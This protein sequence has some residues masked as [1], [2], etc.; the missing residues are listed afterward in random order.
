MVDLDNK[1]FANIYSKILYRFRNSIAHAE[2]KIEENEIKFCNTDNS[3]IVFK[4]R[5]ERKRVEK[6]MEDLLEEVGWRVIVVI[7]NDI[8]D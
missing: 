6:F 8:L 7:Q 5:I 3:K 2:F 4:A 1:K